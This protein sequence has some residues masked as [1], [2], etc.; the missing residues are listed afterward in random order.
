MGKVHTLIASVA[1]A[2]DVQ[3]T[4][5]TYIL[6]FHQVLCI[7]EMVHN[8]ISP[9]QVQMNQ[10][11]INEAPII[12]LRS[13]HLASSIPL[14]AHLI[15][16][17]DPPLQIPLRLNGIMSYF[18]TRKPTSYELENP[19]QFQHITMTFDSPVWDPY[20]TEYAQHEE[21]CLASLNV[22]PQ[23]RDRTINTIST[24]LRSDFD[25]LLLV[26]SI[27]SM[28]LARRK[29]T[30]SPEDLAKQWIIGLEQARRT[31]DRTTQLGVHD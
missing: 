2:Y 12:S 10:I 16:I 29:G 15:V 25:E 22:I 18:H 6:I 26:H 7:K 5:E 11:V 21:E 28:S 30:V 4:N 3:T 20:S 9:F 31:I 8:L 13:T 24:G 17:D 23:P 19:D 1:V 14:D 27:Q